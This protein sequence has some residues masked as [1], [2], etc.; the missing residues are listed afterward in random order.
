[1]ERIDLRYFSGYIRNWKKLCAELEIALPLSRGEREERIVTE[2]F[3]RWGTA[4]PV[5]RRLCLCG[6]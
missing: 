4:L 1:M 5:V 3:A 2:G 6:V